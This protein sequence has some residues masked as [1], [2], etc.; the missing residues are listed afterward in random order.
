MGQLQTNQ[1]Q[2][3]D[4]IVVGAGAMGSAA[5]YHLAQDGQRVLL[6]EQF[7]VGHLR[8]SSHGGSRIIR[9]THEDIDFTRWMPAT[10]A[11]W[12]RLEQ[13]SG[14]SLM[15]MTNGLYFGL[16]NDPFLTGA[17]Q[18]LHMLG[19]PYR[20]L[21][22]NDMRKEFPQFQ[23]D[24]QWL[25]L[26]QTET[27]I[28]AATRC[29]QTLVTQAIQHGA[30]L[31]ESCKVLAIRAE[32]EGV[33]VRYATHGTETEVYANRVVITAGPW[34][35]QLLDPL[36]GYSL[37][38][39]PTHQQVAYFRVENPELYRIG[40]CPIHIFF[41]GNLGAYGFPIYEKPGHVK[42]AIELANIPIDPDQPAV[43]D[44]QALQLLSATVGERLVG[45]DPEPQWAES[46]R[47]TETPNRDFIIDYHPEHPQIIFA[48][49]F[50]GRGFK[51]SIAIGRALADMAQ[52]DPGV[53]HQEFW[54]PRFALKVFAP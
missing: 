17:Q 24:D 3:F 46:C 5:A 52:S 22:A 29:V 13:E 14:Q 49:G 20:L 4:V 36:L 40:C 7:Q 34:V 41:D 35:H 27:G 1:H 26:E 50:S 10:F 44:Q 33:A 6:L 15:Q 11:L 30:T 45:V 25:A 39:T 53:Y 2:H 8:G 48:S 28:L 51:H 31:Q 12:H 54:L 47:Y 42:V 23:L 19:F 43:L 9:Y 21:T 38:L 37:P 18:A 32:G 16:G